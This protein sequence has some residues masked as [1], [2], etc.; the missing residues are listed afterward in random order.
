MSVERMPS[1]QTV[2]EGQNAIFECRLNGNNGQL[3]PVQW[4]IQMVDSPPDPIVMNTTEHYILPPANS[5]LVFDNASLIFSNVFVEC[6]ALDRQFFA[7]LTVQGEF[8]VHI[9]CH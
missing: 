9:D 3:L 2:I 6:S 7:M 5:V 8:N 4:S 1:D